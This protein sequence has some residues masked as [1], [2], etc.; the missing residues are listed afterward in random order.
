MIDAAEIT[1]LVTDSTKIGK[2][3]LASLGA[4]SLIDCIITDE[5]IEEKHKQV[6]F[7][8]NK[9]ELILAN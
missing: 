2:S 6:V 8:D 1:Y 7:K 9:I 4:L 3:A 5:G